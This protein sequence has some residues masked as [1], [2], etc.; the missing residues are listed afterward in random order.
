MREERDRERERTEQKH[1]NTE[2]AMTSAHVILRPVQELRPYQSCGR[3]VS[4]NH[5]YLYLEPLLQA[6]LGPAFVAQILQWPLH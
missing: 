1:S 3:L 6:I 5:K 4:T 2:V